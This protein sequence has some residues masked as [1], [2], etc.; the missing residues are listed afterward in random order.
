MFP[1]ELSDDDRAAIEAL[2]PS[3]SVT[4]VPYFES[5][6]LRSA[7]G[8]GAVDPSLLET[9]PQL[10]DAGREAI[11]SAHVIMALDLPVDL[12]LTASGLRLVQ[13]CGAGTDQ[14]NPAMLAEHDVAVA[15]VSGVAA[16][17]MAEFVIG[18][19][20]QVWKR[21]R[22][23]ESAQQASDWQMFPGEQ[24][25]EK[26]VGIIGLG[27]I[28]RAV[29]VRLRPFGVRLL[30]TRRSAAPGDLDPDVDQ[31]YPAADLTEML[32]E[33]DAVLVSIPATPETTD[34]FD[35]D[36]FATMK[37]GTVFC[38]VGR[39]TLVDEDALIAALDDGPLRAAILDVTRVEPLPESSPLW[40]HPHVYVSGHTSVS[41]DGYLDRLLDVLQENLRRIV[42]GEPLMNVVDPSLGY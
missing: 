1:P 41:L 35:A 2:D 12:A 29:A 30:A 15:N 22:E 17:S 28:G 24:V 31:L 5:S 19:L 7:R 21:T 9:A 25:A 37:P 39:G 36:L 11:A 13:A 20:L 4:H 18:R 40:R 26:T 14:L 32:A 16:P 23:I 34:M 10:D 27:A 6:D 3:I 38:N 33:C 42:A 8:R